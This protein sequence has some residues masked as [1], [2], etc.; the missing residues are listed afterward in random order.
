MISV[1]IATFNGEKFLR[2][3]IESILPQLGVDDEII[4]SD[5]SSTDGTLNILRSFSD[6]RISIFEGQ[7][8]RSPIFNFEFA[9]KKAKGD[10]I[11]LSDQDDI[12]HS[13]KVRFMMSALKS[14]MMVVSDCEIINDDN[15]TLF[16][17]FFAKANSGKG[18][19]KNLYKNTYL[20]CCMAFK[21]DILD[22]A[23]PFP[24][25]IPMH[26]I[27][28]GFVCELYYN[29]M[30][31]H[32]KLT[33]YRKHDN[34]TSTALN[35]RNDYDLLTKISFRINLLKYIPMLLFR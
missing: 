29:S 13:D 15:E 18:L 14:H 8:F 7:N 23:L 10:F 12:W 24:K 3:Q 26:D 20:G 30:F 27:W 25:D 34:N 17:S 19:L 31:I 28:L 35:I 16:N 1:C 2:Q 11:F 22:K 4:I 21:K 33:Y 6:K 9:I 5:D 32:D